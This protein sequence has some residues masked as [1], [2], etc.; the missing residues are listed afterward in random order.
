M[1]F[2][3]YKSQTHFKRDALDC[4]TSYKSFIQCSLNDVGNIHGGR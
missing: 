3:M 1:N 2:Y 4:L